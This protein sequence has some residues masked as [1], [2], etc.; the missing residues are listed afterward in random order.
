MAE[1]ESGV[2]IAEP[3]NAELTDSEM[4][5]EIYGFMRD[6]KNMVADTAPMLDKLGKSSMGK[7]LGLR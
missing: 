7:M 2:E 3:Q 4:L 6:I 5:V 1:T